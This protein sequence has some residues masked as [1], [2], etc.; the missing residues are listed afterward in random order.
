M[1]KELFTLGGVTEEQFIKALRVSI[2]YSDLL[3]RLRI[4]RGDFLVF[5]KYFVSGKGNGHISYDLLGYLKTINGG[6]IVENNYKY[7]L[8]RQYQDLKS[9]EIDYKIE[10][11]DLVKM[12]RKLS[13]FI[14]YSVNDDEIVDRAKYIGIQV[15][16]TEDM[17]DETRVSILSN[18]P[19]K[20]LNKRELNRYIKEYEIIFDISETNLFYLA[21]QAG[22]EVTY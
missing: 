12:A 10:E 18:I 16:T 7:M 13:A 15:R 2:D 9:L 21:K 19:K 1:A 5:Y 6:K 4:N 17:L 8:G 22:L 11:E 20:K 14:D 3:L